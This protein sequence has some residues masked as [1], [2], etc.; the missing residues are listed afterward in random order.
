MT[1][2]KLIIRDFHG[3]R[4]RQRPNDG[5]LSATDMCKA[6][7]KLF[8]DYKRL[9]ATHDFLV[10]LFDFLSKN[11]DMGYP[12]TEQNQQLIQT[13]QG[14]PPRE[15]GT[16]A[17]PFV[18][19]NLAQWCSPKFAVM[20]TG[21]VYELLTK[22]TVSLDFK[23]SNLEIAKFAKAQSAKL[24]ER[25]VVGN[26]KQIALNNSIKA[27]FDCDILAMYN[28]ISPTSAAP[29]TLLIPTDI[30]KRVGLK[31]AKLVNLKLIELGLQ[32]K[33]RDDKNRL[34]YKLTEEGFKY[35]Q[36]QDTGKPPKICESARA[37]RWYKNVLTQF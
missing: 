36:Y 18:A 37:I 3:A 14:G 12:I 31:N 32:T 10:E 29:Q 2:Q 16:W 7:G 19:I 21:W 20:V 8:A 9:N 28:L 26:A 6:T 4:V 23:K 34:Y 13:V 1:T 27:E 35:G 30:A 25:G 33:H 15:Q 24:D 11:P 17:H 5:Y 22:G